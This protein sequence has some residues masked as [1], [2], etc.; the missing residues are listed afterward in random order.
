MN[1]VHKAPRAFTLLEVLVALAIF[2]LS[3]VVLGATYLNV[4]NAYE[5]AA[6]SNEREED[7]R[8]ARLQ[9]LSSSERQPAEEGDT[10]ETPGGE[11][12]RW[13]STIEATGIADLF[14]VTL[15][16]EIEAA[17]RPAETITQSFHVVRPTWADAAENSRLRQAARER[18]AEILRQTP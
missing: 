9:L 11:R 16:C 6:R 3:A 18:I 1:A 8:F 17:N 15:T 5:V 13:R 12:V 14:V 2:A 4:L 10:F 7:I